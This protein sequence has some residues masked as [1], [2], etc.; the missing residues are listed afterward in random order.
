ML[1]IGVVGAGLIAWAH[2]LGLRAM[3]DSGVIDA[4]LSCVF[5]TDPTRM[6]RFADALEMR[7]ARDAGELVDSCDAVWVCTPT[8]S[9]GEVVELVAAA[10]KA[11]FCEKP[12]D[13]DITRVEALTSIVTANAIPAQVGLVLRSTPVFRALRDIVQSEELGEPM[14]VVFRDDQYFPIQGMYGSTWRGDV[15]QAGGGCLIE[16]SIHDLDILRFCLGEIDEVS[17]RTSN[18][19]GH[20]GIEDS[21]NAT[22][23]FASGASAHL[24]S[25][26]HD[27]LS[28]PSTRRVEVFCRRGLV[29]LD[30][31]FLGPLHVQKSDALEERT[32]PLPSW[33]EEL[34]LA[35]DDVGLAIRLYAEAD[36]AFV[37]AVNAGDMPGPDFTE[38]LTAHRL[39]D[40]VYRSA[41]SG[42]VPISLR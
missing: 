40:A 21:A 13:R 28:R 14:A 8:A 35:L 3:A 16:H 19:S 30:D 1:R 25:V 18:F 42:G 12:L 38:A 4:S 36:R 17:G 39:V 31:D 27:I 5:D 22:L 11:V 26:W 37:D 10:G 6:S 20:P 29:W 2:A 15:S 7:T 9:H 41:E 33:V 24:V 32:C 23:R 34:P